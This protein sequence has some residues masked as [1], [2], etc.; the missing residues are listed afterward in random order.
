MDRDED[1]LAAWRSFLH[2][3]LV[4]TGVL[5]REMETETGLPLTWYDVLLNL[6]E[7]G[8]RLRMQE[9]A[10]SIVLS[11]SGL[12]RLVDRMV[13]AGYLAREPAEG[14]RRGLLAVLTPAGKNAL[15]A[16]APVHL[17]GIEQHFGRHVTPEEATVVRAVFDR[18]RNALGEQCDAAIGVDCEGE[19][20]P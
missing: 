2:G 4:L 14:D 17:R 11:K 8:G 13:T 3:H 16:A 6:N 12:T 15:R 18:V 9:L 7:A 20:A 19:D 5:S 10:R 1:M